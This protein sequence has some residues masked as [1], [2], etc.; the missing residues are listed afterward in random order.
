MKH[1]VQEATN[2]NASNVIVALGANAGLLGKEII[3]KKVQVVEN[4]EWVEG[5]ASSVRSGLNALLKTNP[6]VDAVILMVCDQPYVSASLLNDLMNRQ[7]E[8]G[9]PIVACN[10]GEAI[11]PPALFHKNIFPELLQLK[12][13]TGARKIIQQHMKDVAIVSFPKGSIDIDTP[14][15]YDALQQD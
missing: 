14:A 5:M 13:D 3:E 8:T 6:S 11:G 15:D 10:Y 2:S 1:A 9:K 7:R 4:S 12:G